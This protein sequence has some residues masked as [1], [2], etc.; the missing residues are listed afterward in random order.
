MNRT[1]NRNAVNEIA[2][3]FFRGALL[4]VAIWAFVSS[5]LSMSY[6]LWVGVGVASGIADVW[7]A[8]FLF[9][10]GSEPVMGVVGYFHMFDPIILL[11]AGYIAL[12]SIDGSLPRLTSV[13]V[14]I[15]YSLRFLMFR[16]SLF[17]FFSIFAAVTPFNIGTGPL[18]DYLLAIAFVVIMLWFYFGRANT[19][20]TDPDFPPPERVAPVFIGLL[21]PLLVGYLATGLTLHADPDLPIGERWSNAYQGFLGAHQNLIQRRYHWVLENPD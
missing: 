21:V 8:L 4:V 3:T 5:A 20:Y 18:T 6:E 16:V 12:S 11:A 7:R 15:A 13:R 17:V 1:I 10:F 9:A 2:I 14:G 19:A